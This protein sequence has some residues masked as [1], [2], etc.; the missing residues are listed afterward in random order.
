MSFF[1]R[2]LTLTAV[3][4]ALL[5]CTVPQAIA[6]N[7]YSSAQSISTASRLN[8]AACQQIDSYISSS[9]DR[10]NMVGYSIAIIDHGRVAFQKCYGS[11]D[12]NG[13]HTI[14]PQTI[15][16]L[17][18]ITK[19]FTALVLL[20]LVD[21]GKVDLDASIKSY[22]PDGPKQWN[23]ITVRQLASMTA[24]FPHDL[25]DEISWH[26]G[27][28]EEAK[29]LPL[30]FRPGSDYQYSNISYR[31][32]GQ[33]IEK[34]SGKRLLENIQEL[35]I[36]PTG[37]N[38][39]GIITDLRASGKPIAEPFAGP[40][41][42]QMVNYRGP[43]INYASGYLFSNIEDMSK[44]A[45]ALLSGSFV[46][47]KA[48]QTM[49]Y[50]RPPCTSGKPDYWAFGWGAKGMAAGSSVRKVTMN[51]GLPGVASNIIVYPE[52]GVAIV[53]LSNYR[54]KGVYEIAKN[55][56]MMLFSDDKT[57]SGAE[58]AEGESEPKN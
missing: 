58:S 27:G 53:S 8:P 49:W 9:F 20:S 37:M 3:S 56:G 40:Y 2:A 34:V 26:E 10:L 47:R 42:N 22:L 19:T 4:A 38:S 23:Q 46:S 50:E 17:A 7:P 52:A 54:S 6:D 45:N 24:G 51:G 35:I 29:S 57:V 33:I 15:F 32:L 25:P 28:Y 18:S 36:T 31:L 21:E 41:G 39:T 30:K 1:F 44:Y 43:A 48:Y 13:H 11:T 55:V 14:T 12:R 16:G 5:N